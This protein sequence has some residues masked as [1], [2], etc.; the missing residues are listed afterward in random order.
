M[1]DESVIEMECTIIY[2][3]LPTG[4]RVFDAGR[5]LFDDCLPSPVILL[6]ISRSRV[7][8]VTG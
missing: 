2:R 8:C 7:L 1:D 4:A 6:L 3:I 5:G